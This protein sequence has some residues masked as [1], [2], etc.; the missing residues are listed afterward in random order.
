MLFGVFYCFVKFKD[1]PRKRTVAR[2]IVST[3]FQAYF[4]VIEFIE[5]LTSQ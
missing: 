1:G 2:S 4:D 3:V 5:L